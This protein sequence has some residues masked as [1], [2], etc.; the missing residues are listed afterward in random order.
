MRRRLRR[1]PSRRPVPG[2]AL[3]GIGAASAAGFA[4]LARSVARRETDSLDSAARRKTPKARGP[5]LKKLAEV[6]GPLGKP[7]LL[8]PATAALAAYTR[9][10][11]RSGATAIGLSSTASSA[12]CKVLDRTLPHRPAPPGKREDRDEPSFPS[13]HAL[14]T[15]A[16]ALTTAYVLSREGRANAWIAAPAAALLPLISAGGRVALDRHWA[17]DVAGGVLG[18]IAV[19]SVCAAAYEMLPD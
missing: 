4:L 18:G 5:R 7:W 15:T 16:V 13:G 2:L 19:A 8:G 6:T 10:G 3:L 11:S 17:S 14:Q 1:R 12:L 9:P